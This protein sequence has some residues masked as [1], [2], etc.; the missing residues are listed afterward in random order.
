MM[1]PISPLTLIP[2]GI[3]AFLGGAAFDA[4]AKDCP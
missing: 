4:P 1:K 2:V 3:F